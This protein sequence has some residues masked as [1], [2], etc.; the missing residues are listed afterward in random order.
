MPPYTCF[1]LIGH[2]GLVVKL[3]ITRD[4][5][6]LKTNEKKK[7]KIMDFSGLFRDFSE[8]FPGLVWD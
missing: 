2:R 7:K 6:R 4:F 1:L 8:T 3:V 5:E